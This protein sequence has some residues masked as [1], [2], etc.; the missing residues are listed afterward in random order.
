MTNNIS[1]W[2]AAQFATL[3]Q[4]WARTMT[5][6]ERLGPAGLEQPLSPKWTVKEM[7]AHLAFWEETSVPV[8]TSLFRGGPEVPVE[9]WYGGTDLEVGPNDPWPDPDTHNAREA[10]WAHTRSADE[11]LARWKHA[12]EKLKSILATVTE[13]ESRGPIG[14]EWSGAAVCRHIEEHLE[15]VETLVGNKS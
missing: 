1:P 15:K 11:V 4:N 2:V 5:L 12:R 9:Q 8:I 13:E 7:L 6:I 3:D 14:T 10:R